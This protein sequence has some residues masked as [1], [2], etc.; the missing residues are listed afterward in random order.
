MFAVLCW[1]FSKVES[2]HPD[3]LLDYLLAPSFLRTVNGVL[4][5]SLFI[6]AAA[7]VAAGF[8]LLV[9]FLIED[10]LC[11][12]RH[13]RPAT[14]LFVRLVAT[15]LAWFLLQ[16]PLVVLLGTLRLSL[17]PLAVLRWLDSEH[18]IHAS[19]YRPLF[20]YLAHGKGVGFDDDC[21][22]VRQ[23]AYPSLASRSGGGGDVGGGSMGGAP[24]APKG[25]DPR[26]RVG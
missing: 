12:R 10:T 6:A 4:V 20:A 21:Q 11:T 2:E 7:L 23:R 14:P 13:N 26:A 25:I 3:Q 18:A 9:L 1:T 22:L 8:V 16:L 15:T 24:R 19:F 17:L 5:A